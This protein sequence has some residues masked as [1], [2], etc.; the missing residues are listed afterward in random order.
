MKKVLLCAALL[1]TGA[2]GAQPAP[3][4]HS[5]EVRQADMLGVWKAEF[6]GRGHAGTLLLEKHAVYAQSVSGTID[7]NGQRSLLAGD[8]EDGEFTLEE[9]ADGKRIAATWLGE[10]VEG[11]CGREVRGTWTAEGDPAAQAFVLRKH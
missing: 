1:G 5:S 8:V 9:S 2:V 11:S 6:E 4:P 7:R 10:V 3:C